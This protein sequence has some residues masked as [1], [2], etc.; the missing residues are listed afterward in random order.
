[1]QILCRF[2]GGGGDG[3]PML[4]YFS[5]HISFIYV[6]VCQSQQTLSDKELQRRKKPT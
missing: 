5:P 1:M 3:E 4:R 6:W 2:R